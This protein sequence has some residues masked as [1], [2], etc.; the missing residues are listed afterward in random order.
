[1]TQ[2][3]VQDVMWL[4]DAAKEIRHARFPAYF[5][6]LG[7]LPPTQATMFHAIV[8]LTKEFRERYAS[9]WRRLTKC[10]AFRLRLF[11]AADDEEPA[12]EWYV[13]C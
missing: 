8:P 6:S 10:N 7:S 11:D 13:F 9:A 1:M 5:V 12:A 3:N 2:A 4:D